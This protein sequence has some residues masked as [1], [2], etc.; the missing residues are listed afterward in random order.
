MAQAKD[1][2]NLFSSFE[3]LPSYEASELSDSASTGEVSGKNMTRIFGFHYLNQSNDWELEYVQYILSKVDLVIEDFALGDADH[4]IS[5]N[6]FDNLHYQDEYPKLQQKLLFDSVNE[7]LQYR[8]KQVVIGSRKAW[9]RWATLSQRKESLAEELY[10][11]ILVWKNMGDLMADD[12]VDKDMST[13]RGRWL[14]FDIEAFEEGV[15]IEK[16]ILS[17]LIDELVSDFLLY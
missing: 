6:L 14:D 15:E 3:I 13:Q 5:P 12:L 16:G 1:Q 4:V 10:K 8:C 17:C 9:D 2:I 11:E 7:S